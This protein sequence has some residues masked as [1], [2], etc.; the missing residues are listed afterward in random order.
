MHWPFYQH[1]S[2]VFVGQFAVNLNKADSILLKQINYPL[3]T[4]VVIY[5][6]SFSCGVRRIYQIVHAVVVLS[7]LYVC[8]KHLLIQFHHHRHLV[9]WAAI[10][11]YWTDELCINNACFFTGF[12]VS[13]IT[14][15]AM[16]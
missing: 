4:V 10:H 15:E 12:T 5:A 16:N 2:L 6:P 14:C 7:L 11:Y 3:P 9:G 8:I 13:F 1:T